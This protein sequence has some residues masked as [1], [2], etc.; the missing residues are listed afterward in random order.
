MSVAA[1]LLGV[2]ILLSA[3]AL[4]SVVLVVNGI[5]GVALAVRG[6]DVRGDIATGLTRTG[7]S[8]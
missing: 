3:I 5:W 7:R 2:A 1:I 8:V 6:I 4:W